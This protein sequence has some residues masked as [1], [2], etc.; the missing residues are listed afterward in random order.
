MLYR[1]AGIVGRKSDGDGGRDGAAISRSKDGSQSGD[2]RR[3]L[4]W[5]K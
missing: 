5:C 2:N 3:L 4:Q 1:K